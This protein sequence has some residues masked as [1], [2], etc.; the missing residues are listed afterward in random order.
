M[1]P[2]YQRLYHE[3][4]DLEHRMRDSTDKPNDRT[5]ENL[6]KNVENLRSDIETAKSPRNLENRI[7]QIMALLDQARHTPDG[8]MSI[9]D[10]DRYFRMF[11]RI[12]MSLRQFPNY[13]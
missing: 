4:E 12:Q 7:K 3:I 10:A 11:E 9:S 8:F 2:A 1:Q 5:C 13:S 6:R